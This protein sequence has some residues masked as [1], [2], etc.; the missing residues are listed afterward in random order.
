MP[1][2][3]NLDSELGDRDG[4][5]TIILLLVFWA[6]SFVHVWINVFG[7]YFYPM[8]VIAFFVTRWAYKRHFRLLRE[9][10]RPSPDLTDFD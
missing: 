4:N 8:P 3:F 1:R 5:L 2:R 10:S 9:R 6:L 7:L